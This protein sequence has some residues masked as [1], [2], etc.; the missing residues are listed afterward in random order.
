MDNKKPL[1]SVIVPIYNVEPYI[2]QCACS[3][4]EQTYDNL[5]IIFV[6]DCTPDGSIDLLKQTIQNYPQRINQIQIINHEYN[7]GLASARKTGLKNSTGEYIINCDSDDYIEPDMI[8]SLISAVTA[9]NYEIVAFPFFIDHNTGKNSVTK[10]TD[11]KNYFNLNSIPVDTLHFSL[12]NKIIKRSILVNLG[13]VPNANCWEDLAVTARVFAISKST[14]T[15]STPLYHYRMNGN[16]L[17]SQA[18]RKRLLDQIT[19]ARFVEK[20]FVNEGLDKQYARFLKNMKFTAKIKYLR[21]CNRDF[22]AWKRTF[23]ETN[24]GILH[25]RHIPL[26]YRLLF[27]LANILPTKFCQWCSDTLSFKK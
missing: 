4:L 8:S 6:N 23:P 12:S 18:H 5:E 22:A 24:T 20:W 15:I 1:V 13:D 27:Y 25:Y 3:I 7:R 19:V 9:G 21:G 16:S 10:I 17:S 2:R 11:S 26:H 14:T